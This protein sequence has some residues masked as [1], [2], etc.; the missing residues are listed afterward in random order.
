MTPAPRRRVDPVALAFCG[1]LTGLLLFVAY[2]TWMISEGLAMDADPFM[3]FI[4][5]A[6]TCIGGGALLFAVGTVLWNRGLPP[7]SHDDDERDG[8]NGNR[9]IS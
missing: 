5:G 6:A 7:A 2:D 1:G 4:T 8:P 9:D 3:H